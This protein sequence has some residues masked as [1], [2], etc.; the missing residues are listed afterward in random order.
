MKIIVV[1]LIILVVLGLSCASVSNQVRLPG[2]YRLV[3]YE[4]EKAVPHTENEIVAF[5]DR[6]QT[7]RNAWIAN[8]YMCQEFACDLWWNAYLEGIGGC[9]VAVFRGEQGH[10]VVKFHT[11][12]GWLWVEPHTDITSS[13]GFGY[14]VCQTICG[15]DAFDD[16]VNDWDIYWLL[17]ECKQPPMVDV[18]FEEN[19]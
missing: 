1:S 19:K 18:G 13:D 2:E 12:N 7:D 16:C 3:V 17:Q 9:L 5:L 8:E 15:K 4:E 14:E 6:D 10:W 11:N